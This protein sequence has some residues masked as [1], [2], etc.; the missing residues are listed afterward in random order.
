MASTW[1]VPLS[2]R[3]SQQSIVPFLRFYVNQP[4]KRLLTKIC[5]YKRYEYPQ[6][7]LCNKRLW[8]DLLTPKR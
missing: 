4:L 2:Y 7:F 6:G 3:F 8:Y 5:C 1:Q